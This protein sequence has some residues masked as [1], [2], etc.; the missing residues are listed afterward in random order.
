METMKNNLLKISIALFLI[1]DSAFA[2]IPRPSFVPEVDADK[3][4]EAGSSVN[5][6]IL[7]FVGVIIALCCIRPVY[8]FVTGEAEKG[9]NTSKEILIGAVVSSV[10]GGVAFGVMKILG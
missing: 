9:W 6:W 8:F 7:T 10:L 3:L 4:Q 2:E 1:A 5:T